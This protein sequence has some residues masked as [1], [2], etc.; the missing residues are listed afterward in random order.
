MRA[1]IGRPFQLALLSV[2]FA[3]S[4]AFRTIPTLTA[5]G[6]AAELHAGPAGIALFGSAFHWGF[7]LM[8]IPV[9]IALDIFG[10]RR[11]VITLSWLAVAGASICALAQDL[12]MLIVGQAL[13]G[14]GCAPA[15]MAALVFTA[16]HWPPRH[17]AGISGTVMA[18]GGAGMLLT[19]TPLAWLIEQWSWRGAFI[20]IAALLA[21]NTCACVAVLETSARPRAGSLLGEVASAV[22]GLRF[23]LTGRRQLALLALALVSYGASI[24]IRG[25]WLVPMFVERH[26]LSLVSAGNVVLAISIAM[27]AAPALIGR[28]DPGDSKRIAV[29]VGM[30]C[31][32]ALT[33][34]ALAFTGTQ[35]LWVDV[36][37]TLLFGISSGYFVL[38]YAEVRSSYPPELMGRGLTAF[39]MG[40]F[41]GAALA[42]S[43]SGVIAALA[44]TQGFDAIDAVLLFL[45]ASLS[46]GTAVFAVLIAGTRRWRSEPTV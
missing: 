33:I 42:Q 24:T 18:A 38:A 40:M 28:L 15:L 44:Q 17:F 20:F 27:I 25:L 1:P 4:N 6:I 3:L 13:I 43:L 11:T 12:A 45:A 41:L 23:V 35:P 7:A 8:Q 19:G 2:G 37:V 29:I 9:G 30:A 16:R 5:G 14:I 32:F 36:T 46:I 22:S 39:N 21:V 34:V 31:V 26:G 10:P